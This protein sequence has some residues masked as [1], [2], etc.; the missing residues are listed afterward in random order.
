MAVAGMG[1]AGCQGRKCKNIF[2]MDKKKG[3]KPVTER[4]PSDSK[5]ILTGLLTCS[6][7]FIPKNSMHIEAKQKGWCFL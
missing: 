6:M 4:V 3:G 1:I 5:A 2:S 7:L